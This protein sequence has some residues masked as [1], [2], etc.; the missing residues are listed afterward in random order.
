[1]VICENKD[2]NGLRFV[3]RKRA[4]RA[5]ESTFSWTDRDLE[6]LRGRCVALRTAYGC[7]VGRLG[8]G[9]KDGRVMWTVTGLCFATDAVK[10]VRSSAVLPVV[11]LR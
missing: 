6:P 11:V 8:L 7:R 5:K 10:S 3:G 1:M 9:A 2:K 4:L